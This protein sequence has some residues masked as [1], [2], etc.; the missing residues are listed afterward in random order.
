MKLI[1]ICCLFNAS[2][3]SLINTICY[4]L[5]LLFPTFRLLTD[6][7]SVLDPFVSQNVF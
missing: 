6:E 4:K 1:V 2:F 7:I 3:R 5:L